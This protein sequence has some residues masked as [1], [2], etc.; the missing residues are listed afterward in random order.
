MTDTVKTIGIVGPGRAGTGLGLALLSAGYDVRLH[1]RTARQLPAPL[2]SSWGATPPWLD[3]VDVVILA[4]PDD[5]LAEVAR[6]LDATGSVGE[7]HTVL[8]LSGVLGAGVL[9]PLRSSG[10]AV[11]SLHPLQSL[12]DPM[13]AP[14]RLRGAAAAIEGE[15][16]AMGVA[17]EL[18]RAVGLIPVGVPSRAKPLYHAAAVFASNYLVAVAA[19]ARRLLV[20]AGVPEDDAWRLLV[21]L[22]RGTVENMILQGPEEALTGP[23]ARGDVETIRRHLHALPN[24]E[25]DLY[26]ALGRAALRLV[27]LDGERRGEIERELEG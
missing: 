16:R 11:G 20:T 23:V 22:I 12:S 1:G 4:V 15:T 18:A 7:R 25:A 26:R 13:S 6:A 3:E 19:T 24:V 10:A 9:G 8:H 27:E 2:E 17:A 14:E 5:A 21:P